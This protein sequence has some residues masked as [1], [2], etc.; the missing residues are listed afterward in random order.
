MKIVSSLFVEIN[1]TGHDRATAK[2]FQN[3]FI[4]TS[5][6]PGVP[7]T[8]EDWAPVK[9]TFT[10]SES[11]TYHRRQSKMN[12]CISS[13]DDN[14]STLGIEGN[15]FIETPVLFYVFFMRK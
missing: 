15:D 1:L 3:L 2:S 14:F 10:H 12:C 5:L 8:R 6:S 9:S 13:A 4:T 7:I 11:F